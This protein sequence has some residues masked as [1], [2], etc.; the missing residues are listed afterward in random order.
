MEIYAFIFTFIFP[1][2]SFS[3]LDIWIEICQCKDRL[4]ENLYLF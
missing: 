1:K 3:L 4:D 2:D